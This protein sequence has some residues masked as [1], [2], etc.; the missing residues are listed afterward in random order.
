MLA[1]IVSLLAIANR[2]QLVLA[3]LPEAQELENVVHRAE[4]CGEPSLGH[5]VVDVI[6]GVEVFGRWV[7][8]I[9]S[10]SSLD[11]RVVPFEQKSAA[12]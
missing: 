3:D 12:R 5:T 4:P 9:L 10:S 11:L 8:A 7:L 1:K 6:T 2:R